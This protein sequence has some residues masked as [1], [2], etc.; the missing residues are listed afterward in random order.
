MSTLHDRLARLADE[1]DDASPPPPDLWAR[2]RRYGRRRTAGAVALVLAGL[3]ALGTGVAALAP[4]GPEPVQPAQERA[5]LRLPDRLHHPDPWTPGTDETGPIGPLVAVLGAERTS[6]SGS[7]S[8]VAA[9][10]ADGTYAFLDLAGRVGD[11]ADGPESEMALSADGRHLAYWYADA[12]DP[13]TEVDATEVATGVA[14]LDT[15][16][17][18]TVRRPAEDA[19]LGLDPQ[20]LL[21]TGDVLWVSWWPYD[22]IG[23]NGADA[24]ASSVL[25]EV[26]AWDVAS[27]EQTSH[28][29]RGIVT[30]VLGAT[31]WADRFVTVRQ[32][33]VTLVDAAGRTEVVGRVTDRVDGPPQVDPSGTRVAFL[34]DTDP[35]GEASDAAE[36]VLV[37]RLPDRPGDEIALTAV[38][39]EPVDRVLGW[40]S[41]REV[42]TLRYTP[43]GARYE[44][45]DV[46]S[47]E[48]TLLL[49]PPAEPWSPTAQIAADALAAPSYDAPAPPGRVDPRALLAGGLALAVLT[50]L[51]GLVLGRRRVRA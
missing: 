19:P 16:T 49:T 15:V 21:W 39:G 28:A 25:Q 4:V 1:A 34:A 23:A 33:A 42:V 32:R 45:V 6:W 24:S 30:R 29:G 22:E 41:D 35:A 37:G 17:G 31:S 20:P 47:G 18:E 14:V 8:G 9:V 2:G 50:A 44:S 43:R 13:R 10:G 36:P 11:G 27:G 12:G 7:R 3:V 48:R 46:G 5:A 26:V 38:P 51:V 40:R